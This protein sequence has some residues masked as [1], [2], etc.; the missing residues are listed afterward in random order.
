MLRTRTPYASTPASTASDDGRGG[1]AID[2]NNMPGEHPV[3]TP[4]L[5]AERNAYFFDPD[6][7]R[8][9]LPLAGGSRHADRLT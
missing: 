2:S 8:R 7:W 5:R 6:A 9:P 3:K 1:G 4:A